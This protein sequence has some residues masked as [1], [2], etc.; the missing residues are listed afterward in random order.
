MYGEMQLIVHEKGSVI[1]PF[2]RTWIYARR[3]NV[4]SEAKLTSSWPLDGAR[5]AERWWFA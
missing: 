2:F 3:A 1:V 4:Q 5:G